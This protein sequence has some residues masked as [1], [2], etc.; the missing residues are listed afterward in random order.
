MQI[1]PYLSSCTKVKSKWIKD[2]HIKPDTL[3]LI[4][5]KIGKSL[6]HIST[7]EILLNRTPMAHV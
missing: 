7:G 2:F 5:E 3:N 4:D 1:D 6:E